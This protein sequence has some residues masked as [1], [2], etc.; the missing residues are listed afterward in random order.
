MMR[1]GIVAAVVVGTLAAF[2]A[3]AAADTR[4]SIP[5]MGD[6]PQP[7]QQADQPQAQQ[8][9]QAAIEAPTHLNEFVQFSLDDGCRYSARVTGD[10]LPVLANNDSGGYALP[11]DPAPKEGLV[12]APDLKITATLACPNQSTLYV[13]QGVDAQG[14]MTQAELL[15]AIG[16]RASVGSVNAGKKCIYMPEFTFAK[17]HLVGA[18][19]N[20]L[21]QVD[22]GNNPSNTGETGSLP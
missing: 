6:N 14:P 16:R 9:D 13:S 10:V 22:L 19:M 2:P 12:V 7:R 20:Y 1:Q 15:T 8:A 21:C 5:P 18:N 11:E 4:T 3:L 17:Q